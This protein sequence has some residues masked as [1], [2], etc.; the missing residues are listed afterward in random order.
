MATYPNGV[1][2]LT[3]AECK[4]LNNISVTTYDTYISSMLPIVERSIE[5]YCRRRFCTYSWT[6]WITM[7]REIMT[8]NWPINNVLL[9]GNPYDVVLI[10]DTTN[11]YNFNIVQTTS[12]NITIDG[13][14]IATNT[15]TLVTSSFAFATYTTIGALKTQ[16]EATL[17]GVTFAYQDNPTPIT[18]STLSTLTLRNGS[19][20]TLTAGINLFDATTGNPLGN[21]YRIN[22]N[23]DRIIMNPNYTSSSYSL[24]SGSYNGPYTTG[25]NNIDGGNYGREFYQNQD[26]L[27]IYNAGYSTTNMPATLKWVVASI[28][29]DVMSLYDVDGNGSYKGL[30]KSETLGD[31]S[32]TLGDGASLANIIN[33]YAEQL[34]FWKKKNI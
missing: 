23:S 18:F 5:D 16:V 27:L 8:D 4:S 9:I 6:Q 2:I 7:D 19:G 10:T 14:F 29:R 25:Y 24:S 20:K 30:M 21:V 28:I 13:A 22:D 17:S 12:N 32:Y 31:Y 11:S 3:L 26:T 33:R 15:A 34:D 1:S